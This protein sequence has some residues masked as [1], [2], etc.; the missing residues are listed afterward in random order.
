M[1]IVKHW[2]FA[3]FR[4]H[5]KETLEKIG[6]ALDTKDVVILGAPVGSG[7]SPIAIA[8]ASA[9]DDAHIL[10]TQK[11][12][13][14]QYRKDFSDS[15]YIMQGKSN[16]PCAKDSS[17]TCAKG[18][19][20]SNHHLKCADK[21][22]KFDECPFY[23]AVAEAWSSPIILHNFAS[24]LYQTRYAKLF[25]P[26]SVL[27]IDEAHNVEAALMDFIS[28]RVNA[29]SIGYAIPMKERIEDY[30]EVLKDVKDSISGRLEITKVAFMSADKLMREKMA[31][32][33]E[34][35]EKT[36][37]KLAFFLTQ[38]E[39]LGNWVFDYGL[40]NNGDLEWLEMKPIF[41]SKFAGEFLFRFGTKL[42]VMSATISPETFCK[43]LGIP[44]EKVFH[45]EIPSTFP[46]ENRPI[47]RTY[48]GKINNRT[49]DFMLPG[50]A[51][52][53]TKAL[54]H[55]PDSKGIIHT[56]T[57]KISNYI[58]EN[59]SD[60]HHR[61]IFHGNGSGV[62]REEAIQQHLMSS[63]AT[64]LVSP[65]MTEGI[66]LVG[67]LCRWQIMC[68]V[69]FLYM[70][71]KQVKARMDKDMLWFQYSAILTIAQASGRGVRSAE[72]HAEFFI[73]DETFERLYKNFRKHFPQW[74]CEAVR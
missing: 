39:D 49:L 46:V 62:S 40:D 47:F 72:D 68:K 15:I 21:E 67:D 28:F 63:K 26:R 55:Y 41:V 69:P 70:G 33:I 34:D 38:A 61:L 66:D 24:F 31:E 57:Y 42:V 5:Q 74:F 43:S 4:H 17:L 2:P 58:K 37:M 8:I 10:T 32:E 73:L 1:D 54:K 59:V 29:K 16:Y 60:R 6:K 64:V 22:Q 3:T 14:A 11:S 19:C 44:A 12:L 71:D 25:E 13:Q 52:K 35:L 45:M 23:M 65:G 9:F 56:H 50:I 48:V 7:K 36:G 27:I 51:E 30:I 20:K 18:P 53:V